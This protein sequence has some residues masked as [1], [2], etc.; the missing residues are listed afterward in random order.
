MCEDSSEHRKVLLKGEALFLLRE[1]RRAIRERHDT[2]T[3]LIARACSGLDTAVCQEPGHGQSLYPARAKDEVEIGAGECVESALSLDNNV[4]RPRR[5]RIDDLRSPASA[6]KCIRV[7][8]AF[9]D[10]VR[11]RG[12]LAIAFRK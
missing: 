7:H 9:E 8:N 11:F 10:A 5:E 6:H 12:N 3:L 4:V 2:E 1:C